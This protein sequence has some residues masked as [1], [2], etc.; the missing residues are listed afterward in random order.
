MTIHFMYVPFTGLGIRKGFR[1]NRWLK[2]R[3]RVFKQFVVPS[4]I[5]QSRREFVLWISWRPEERNNSIVQD[6]KRS[7][8]GI[9][10][11]STVFTYGGVCFWDD[12]YEEDNLLGRLKATLPDLES[13]V[14]E[15]D[16]IL[17]TIQP[18]DDLYFGDVVAEF[19]DYDGPAQAIGYRK[20]YIIN[21]ATKEIAEYNPD[22]P[23][24][25]YTIRFRKED[26]IDP[27]RHYKFI[28]PYKSH[29]YVGDFL[30]LVHF[31]GRKFVV[32]THGENIS[33]TYNHPY[34]GR[35]LTDEERD[36]VLIK[37]GTYFSDPVIV[38]RGVRLA[39][40]KVF[41]T[42]PFQDALRKFYHSLPVWLQRL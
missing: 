10:G 25:F 3:I 1:G 22:T 16:Q 37:T 35:V 26:F 13:Y 27:E 24:P 14:A 32:G 8:E 11:M 7:L 40:R 5:N 12:K 15:G 38:K 2:N 36:A 21:Y 31:P 6:F 18:S 30:K 41:N 34:K 9:R 33:T 39:A 17:L 20:G 42:M 23:P 29:E 28:G 19:Q 4:L